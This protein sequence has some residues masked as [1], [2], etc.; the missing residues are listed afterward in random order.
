MPLI[1]I[2]ESKSHQK[3]RSRMQY[4][5]I[6]LQT[7]DAALL[8][9]SRV[10][11]KNEK[12]KATISQALQCPSTKYTE[13]NHPVSE[14]DRIL[15]YSRARNS[16]YAIIALYTHFTEYLQGILGEMYEHK[17]LLVVG[18]AP[19]TYSIAF[20]EVVKLG[21]FESLSEHMV[22]RVF[23]SLEDE[24]STK[25]LLDRILSY[26]GVEIDEAVKNKVLGYLEMRHIFV[27]R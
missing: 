20:A 14:Q 12:P 15:S 9:A 27:H 16:K 26:T 10:I 25:K 21:S 1:T 7:V 6:H 13:L 24:R 23:R 11:S 18:K 17:P 8:V 4:L 2:T 22:S 19:P 5:C 3:L